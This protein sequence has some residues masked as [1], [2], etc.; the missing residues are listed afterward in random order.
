[1]TEEQKQ[2]A[3]D[4]AKRMLEARIDCNHKYKGFSRWGNEKC[5]SRTADTI[6]AIERGTASNRQLKYW[7][8]H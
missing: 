3:L 7:E 8:K 6:E 1:M 5:I 4:N 2:Q